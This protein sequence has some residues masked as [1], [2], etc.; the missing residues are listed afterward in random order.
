MYPERPRSGG[1]FLP[2]LRHHPEMAEEL[3]KKKQRRIAVKPNSSALFRTVTSYL[4]VVAGPWLTPTMLDEPGLGLRVRGEFYEVES[5]RMAAIDS[6]EHS[7]RT[8][9][10]KLT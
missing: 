3:D 1:A 7:E 4:M 5:T 9:A 2:A 8:P 6:I 10:R